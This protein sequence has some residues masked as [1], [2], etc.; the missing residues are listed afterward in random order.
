MGSDMLKVKRVNRCDI[1]DKKFTDKYYLRK[2]V[3]II[4]GKSYKCNL[5]NNTFGESDSLN[6]H[7]KTVH[8][9]IEANKCKFCDERF[10]SKHRLKKFMKL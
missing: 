2:H 7:M 1:C 9:N 8:F 3:K 6:M 4:H 10:V 5:C